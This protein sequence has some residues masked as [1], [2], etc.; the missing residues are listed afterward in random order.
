[1][2]KENTKYR[3]WDKDN[4]RMVY[5]DEMEECD[6]SF[7]EM[8]RGEYG[9]I[10]TWHMGQK[11]RK[12]KEVYDGDIVKAGSSLMIIENDGFNWLATLIC[13][14]DTDLKENEKTAILE[15]SHIKKLEVVGNKFEN[16]NLLKNK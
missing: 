16:K 6:V 11:D 12:G 5:F 7:Y 2:K 15:K 1:M 13:K 9:F 10:L 8:A 14:S 3:A 4:K